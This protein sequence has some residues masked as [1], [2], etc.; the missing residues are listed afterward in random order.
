MW[1]LWSV[2]PDWAV[3][4]AAGAPGWTA[5]QALSTTTQ[6]ATVNKRVMGSI[7]VTSFY[8]SESVYPNYA[9]IVYDGARKRAR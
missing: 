6:H 1:P 9:G 5:V 4:A 3:G 8:V 2:P 7:G